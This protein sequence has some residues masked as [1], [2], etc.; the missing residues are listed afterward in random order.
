MATELGMQHLKSV[1][2]LKT[3][4]RV[5][6]MD[7]LLSA[8]RKRFG[9]VAFWL[10]MAGL[11]TP[12]TAASPEAAQPVKV[13][14][15]PF[16][17]NA[18]KD[19]DYLGTQI[20]DVLADHFR[21]N[22]A[23][24]VQLS[25]EEVRG[26]MARGLDRP[27]QIRPPLEAE[28]IVWGSF[29]RTGDQFRLD[30]RMKDTTGKALPLK[31]H[32][33]GVQ[34]ENLLKVL[35]GLA[36][37][38]GLKLFQREKVADVK[39]AGNRR[40]EADAI[41]RVIET[42]A[43]SVYHK[44]QI[45]KDIKS[46]FE[47]GYF[48]DLRVDSS[49]G[50]EGVN[51]TFHVKEKPTIRRIKFTGNLR[52]NDED[53]KENLTITTGAILN[54][55]KVRNNIEHIESMYKEKNY[56]QAQVTYKLTS[57]ANN[58]ADIEFNIEEGP[59]LYVTSILFEGNKS[60]NAKKLKKQIQTSEKGFF[61]WFTSSGDLDR[62]KL[63]QDAALLAN[64]YLNQG[65]INARVA[66]PQIDL[67]EE[68]IQV[69]FKIDEGAR[70]KVGRIDVD[71]DLILPK[72]ELLK[73]LELGKS[74]YFNRE[75]LRNDVIALTDLYGNQ[76]YA[77]ADVKPRVRENAERLIVDI[78]YE[79]EKKQEVYYEKIYIDGNTR[80][81]DKV[82]RRELKVHEQE[83]F[84]GAALKKSIR[85]LYRLNY[86]EDI[87][88]D[89]LRGS[90]DDKM[91]LKLNVTEKPTGQFQFGAG[92]SS[93][94]NVFLIGSVVENNFLGRGQTLKVE[95]TVGSSTQRYNVG[96][97]EPW[98]FDIPLSASVNVYDQVKDYIDYD[99][100]S[101]GGSLGFSY[102]IFE[103][104]RV[105]CSYAYD[106]SN[107]TEIADDADETIKELEGTL[108]TSSMALSLGYDSRDNIVT[109]TEGSK[110]IITFEYAGLGGDVGFK[111][112]MAETGWYFPLFKGLVGF[113]HGRAGTVT[114]NGGDWVLPDY[115]KFY[116]GGINSLRGFDYRDIHITNTHEE[117]EAGP[118]GVLGTSDDVTTTVETET[119]GTEMAQFNFEIIIPIVKKMGIMGVVFFDAGN[120]Y[121]DSI[122][123]GDLRRTAGYGFR[124]FSPLAPI[125]IEYGRVLDRREGESS[126]GWEFTM[127]S[128]F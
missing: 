91:V 115:E 96:F 17:I 29:T 57:L 97:T 19:L 112:V 114:S 41:A 107:V 30:A 106:S 93:E 5:R 79:I 4:M 123:L 12:W 23:V 55:Y 100:D 108:V 120:V 59:K 89:S 3:E 69:T 13:T 25:P 21:R 10:I 68:N 54:I 11:L 104:T 102:P 34:L 50:P 7:Q 80:T 20:A 33:E 127:G 83:R 74:V 78:T 105:Y 9:N 67:G 98:L 14:V 73:N 31:F 60:F 64:F 48:D 103:Y 111:K 58:Q 121:E 113:I 88:V 94:E 18:T 35:N 109:P 66:D 22:G 61:Y 43:G 77:Y 65:Y 99:R 49:T 124:W 27:D 46:I 15:L 45:S 36:G 51:V 87:K 86:F 47:M 75:E 52:F 63:D 85:R 122:D 37:Q 116:L 16:T 40:I 95:G 70:F 126:G 2:A 26:I 8:I 1:I 117:T 71:G 28:R 39:I 81:R 84:D 62:T 82:I 38:I 44:N 119:G 101:S 90:A 53:L 125:R 92:Y 32:A 72:E 42:K 118:D 128:A 76:G 56:H 6:T 24:I 110:N